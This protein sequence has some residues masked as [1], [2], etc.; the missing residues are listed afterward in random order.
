MG[1]GADH[2]YRAECDARA[3]RR[4]QRKYAT[5]SSKRSIVKMAQEAQIRLLAIKSV[6][7]SLDEK[8]KA[9]EGKTAFH[10]EMHDVDI[11]VNHIDAIIKGVEVMGVDLK[12]VTT[13]HDHHYATDDLD[14]GCTHCGVRR[15]SGPIRP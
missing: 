5:G 9:S 4:L 6:Y 13:T 15:R 11:L 3:V 8:V 2:G 12:D 14:E 7:E 10:D 1:S